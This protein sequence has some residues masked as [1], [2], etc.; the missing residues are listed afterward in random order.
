[1]PHK[2]GINSPSPFISAWRVTKFRQPITKPN[3]KVYL[4]FLFYFLN[5]I[6]LF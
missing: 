2:S 1:M 5:F 6:Y 4:Y 3:T